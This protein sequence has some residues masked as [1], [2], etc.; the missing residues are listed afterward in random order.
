MTQ[1]HPTTYLGIKPLSIDLDTPHHIFIDISNDETENLIRRLSLIHCPSLR[2]ILSRHVIPGISDN[3]TAEDE[4]RT[5]LIQ[6]ALDNFSHLPPAS[7]SDLSQKAIVPVSTGTGTALLRRPRDTVAGDVAP[8]FFPEEARTPSEGFR[9]RY[10]KE[11]NELGM[12]LTINT[13]ILLER[14]D[15]YSKSTRPYNQ[16]EWKVKILF[17][18]GNPSQPLPEGHLKL[19]WIPARSLVPGGAQR[20]FCATECRNKESKRLLNYAMAIM[21][22][23]VSQL[24][25]DS[26]GWSG[27]ISP[28]HL[29]RQLETAMEAEDVGALDSLVAYWS[30]EENYTAGSPLEL[31][32]RRWIPGATSRPYLYYTSA[33]I[34][35]H[36]SQGLAPHFGKIGT[37]RNSERVEK[38][39]TKIGVK[40]CPTF[41]QVHCYS[42]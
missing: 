16:I 24:W 38:F 11:L 15:A 12:A 25:I 2:D 42:C 32:T 22:F 27:P 19:P 39:F 26:L 10:F 5:R 36:D 13:D 3:G 6:Y 17:E 40:R 14:I 35:F 4:R 1:G 7:R 34:F 30:I 31:E 8:L 29:L 37:Y 18:S 21:E 28:E 41:E 23:H 9:E 20:F 33:E